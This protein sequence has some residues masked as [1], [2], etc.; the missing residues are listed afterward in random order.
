MTEQ[1]TVTMLET[2]AT[3]TITTDA[4]DEVDTVRIP[5]SDEWE[6]DTYR[7]EL[8][9][10][11]WVQVDDWQQDGPD[12]TAHVVFDPSEVSQGQCECVARELTTAV[13]LATERADSLRAVRDEAIRAALDG[14]ASAYRVA[15]IVGLS[16]PMVA[17]IRDRA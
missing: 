3:L 17:K 4:G 7:E 9:N 8:A 12:R 5:E 10:F 14:G 13:E 15:Q 1:F 11:G 6:P 2:G 16:Q